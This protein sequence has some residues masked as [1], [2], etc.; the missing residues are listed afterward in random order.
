MAKIPQ[1]RKDAPQGQ[2]PDAKGLIRQYADGMM[3]VCYAT[4][5]Q[6]CALIRANIAETGTA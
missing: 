2:Y 3:P 6:Q 1:T 5:T 4:L